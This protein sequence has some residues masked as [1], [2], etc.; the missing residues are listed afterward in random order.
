MSKYNMKK[1]KSK[2]SDHTLISQQ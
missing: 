1:K 2:N